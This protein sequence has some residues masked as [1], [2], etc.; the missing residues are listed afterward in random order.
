ML[1]KHFGFY[2]S[3][4]YLYIAFLFKFLQSGLLDL[5][6]SFFLQKIRHNILSTSQQFWMIYR[7]KKNS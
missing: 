5:S 3:C 2:D 6:D 7:N 1:T 4:D